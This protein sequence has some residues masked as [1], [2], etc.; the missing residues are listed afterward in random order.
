[1]NAVKDKT[2]TF[3]GRGLR[4][5]VLAGLVSVVA[6]C[7]PLAD[8]DFWNQATSFAGKDDTALGLSEVVAGN[9]PAA[10]KFLDAAITRN[11][12]NG[13]ALLWR[14]IV[15]QNTGRPD[16][17]RQDYSAIIASNAPGTVIMAG[18]TTSQ[19]HPLR[20]A[21]QFNLDRLEKGLPGVVGLGPQMMVA[22]AAPIDGSSMMAAPAGTVTPARLAQNPTAADANVAKRFEIL[23]NLQGAGLITP[24]EFSARRAANLGALLPMSAPAP[25]AYLDRE[26]PDG[27]EI[28]DR[29][30]QLN[31]SLQMGAITVQDHVNERTAILDGLLPAEPRER[32]IPAPAPQGLMDAARKISRIED[33]QKEKLITPTE[34]TKERNAIEASIIEPANASMVSQEGQPVRRVANGA[35]TPSRAVNTAARAKP[36]GGAASSV[37]TEIHLAS[38]RNQTQAERG[39]LILGSRFAPQLGGLDHEIRKVSVPGKGTFYRLLAD[40]MDTS[41]ATQVCAEL[42]RRGQYCDVK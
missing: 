25:A 22:G 29:L 35:D 11:P 8:R 21:A 42:K 38:Y 37:G 7:A 27:R 32:A 28:Q 14:G 23:R 30:E 19:L 5:A 15:Y 26:P 41:K 16:K 6:A 17:A 39:W 9:Y 1:M 31:K 34:F 33:L 18:P 2:V 20:D 40:G 4:V 10:E 36:A 3:L 12:L 24:E 13:Q